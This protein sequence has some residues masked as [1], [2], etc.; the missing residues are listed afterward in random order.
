MKT[1]LVKFGLWLARLGGWNEFTHGLDP[2]ILDSAKL[3]TTQAETMGGSGEYR[4]REALRAMMNRHPKAPERD[5]A[6]AI[7]LALRS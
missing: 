6:L 2:A 5:L 7:E 1:L 4:R 3:M